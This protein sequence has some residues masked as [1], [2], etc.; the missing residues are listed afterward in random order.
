MLADKRNSYV[1]G[2]V[3]AAAKEAETQ[4]LWANIKDIAGKILTPGSMIHDKFKSDI[5]DTSKLGW[6]TF[7][8]TIWDLLGSFLDTLVAQLALNLKNGFFSSN[9]GNDK[10]NININLESLFTPWSSPIVAGIKGAEDKFGSLTL[11]KMNIGGY[12]NLLTKLST[13]QDPNNPGPTD[14]VLD[15]DLASAIRDKVMVK[16]L[17]ENILNRPFS[18]LSNKSE[19]PKEYFS[20]RG[21][22]ILRKYRIVPV[23]WEYAAKK[24]TELG[25]NSADFKVPT[26]KQ[27]MDD[28]YKQES[29]YFGLIDPYWVLKAP[30]MFCR[31][32]GFGP[33]NSFSND[34]EGA[35]FRNN[36]CADEQQCLKEDDNGSCITYGYCSEERKIW[37]FGKSCEERYNT[38]N[39]YVNRVGQTN[40]WL[41]NTLDFRDCDQSV[42]GCRWFSTEYNPVSQYWIGSN[43][44]TFYQV[45]NTN[46]DQKVEISNN[47]DWLVKEGQYVSNNKRLIMGSLCSETLCKD[48]AMNGKCSFVTST[49][50]NFCKIQENLSCNIP[51]GGINCRLPICDSQENAFKSG[52]GGFEEQEG[53]FSENAKKWSDELSFI[54][55]N[56]RAYR[57]EKG[58]KTG[59]GLR[60]LANG[61][62]SAIVLNSDPFAVKPGSAYHLKF[63]IRGSVSNQG[64]LILFVYGGDKKMTSND[65]SD[66]KILN[67]IE[68]GASNNWNIW[69]PFRGSEFT[70]QDFTTATIGIMAS[71]G[72]FAD[73]RLDNF[74]LNEVGSKCFENSVTV[75]SEIVTENSETIKD[76]Y[77]DRD[78]QVCSENSV[79]CSQFLR[80]KGGVGTNL[81]YN[82][83]FEYGDS[84]WSKYWK[85]DNP[86]VTTSDSRARLKYSPASYSEY[87]PINVESGSYYAVSFDASQIASGNS[88]S[89]RFEMIFVEDKSYAGNISLH[90]KVIETNCTNIG[91]DKELNFIFTPN[92]TTMERKSCWFKVPDGAKVMMFKPF[93]YKSEDPNSE[94][95]IY[96]DNLKIEKVTYPALAPT[97]YISYDP[98]EAQSSQVSYLKKAPDYFNCYYYKADG[99]KRWPTTP[100]EL[101]SVLAGRSLACLYFAGVCIPSEVGCELYKPLNGDPTVPGVVN[102]IDACPQ[103]CAGYQVYKQESTNFVNDKYR[104]FIA[105]KK[106]NY[107]SASYVGC[108]EFTNL[109]ELGRGAEAKEYYSA[110]RA[111]QKPNVDDGAYYTCLLYTSPSP[112]DS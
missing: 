64:K 43:Q 12:Y 11:S 8:D 73:I 41:T 35:I 51:V 48:P 83:G 94:Y 77:F 78:A 96:F 89:V 29:D 74:S 30:E 49:D 26:L 93:A 87:R 10:N 5:H 19:N 63:D 71:Q 34:Q 108:D 92:S 20:L 47:S 54:S 110:I 69:T 65:L 44:N 85:G 22:T 95:Y 21:I 81:I 24:I 50:G 105:D 1:A 55:N 72:T 37:N 42:V 109:D 98:G 17:P 91:G 53:K 58:G 106:V 102:D 23:G 52:N 45:N 18:S 90:R 3:E 107:C 100:E 86:I 101:N 59:A 40:Y 14:C 80:L 15:Q 13:C 62:P 66:I 67:S 6:E 99:I 61:T 88:A 28:F 79:G 27:I 104:Q 103:E 57:E 9:Y 2:I 97:P 70:V 39:T 31:R 33:Q 75:F 4:G 25:S 32:E 56:N 111:C 7:T 60:I 46:G 36:Y 16:D 68:I 84:E 76:I 38:C 82:G 112:R